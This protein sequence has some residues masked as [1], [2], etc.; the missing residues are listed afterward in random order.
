MKP[1]PFLLELKILAATRPGSTPL[2]LSGRQKQ[3]QRLHAIAF[4][5]AM[6]H[7]RAMSRNQA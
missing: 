7:V 2:T 6:R 1:D 4:R 3:L 5:R